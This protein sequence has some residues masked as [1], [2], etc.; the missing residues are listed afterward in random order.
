MFNSLH[1]AIMW[2]RPV[3]WGCSD[4]VPMKR[5][6]VGT[7]LQTQSEFDIAFSKIKGDRWNYPFIVSRTLDPAYDI[8]F[9]E[10]VHYEVALTT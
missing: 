5:R 3:I 1:P 9:Y 10:H 4:D 6:D 7:L 8:T 2:F